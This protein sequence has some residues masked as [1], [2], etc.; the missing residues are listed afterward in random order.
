MF[1]SCVTKKKFKQLQ[2]NHALELDKSKASETACLLELDN[3]KRALQAN[4]KAM[5]DKEAELKLAKN[6]L[7]NSKVKETEL[8]S[9][10]DYLR[11]N[12]TQLLNRLSD[13]SVVNK[14]GFRSEMIKARPCAAF[15]V[16]S[17]AINGG[18]FNIVIKRPL[19]TPQSPPIR[20]PTRIP[21]QT[22][23]CKP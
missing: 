5:Q 17:V 8:K 18:N 21:V 23:R 20:I 19:I 7:D 12:N 9:Q 11:E 1:S 6:D 10:L 13:L 4:E 2:A 16:A 15:I 14:T 22:F 3:L